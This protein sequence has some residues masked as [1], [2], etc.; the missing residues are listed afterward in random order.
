MFKVKFV[1]IGGIEII[2]ELS[3]SQI[4]D[5]QNSLNTEGCYALKPEKLVIAKHTL[6]YYEVLS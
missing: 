5:L 4:N 6:L 1:F 3:K 2:E